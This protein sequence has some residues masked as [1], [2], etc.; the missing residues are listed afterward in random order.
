M[1]KVISTILAAASLSLAAPA[2]MAAEFSDLPQEHWAYNA[3]SE[4]SEAG[5]IS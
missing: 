3:V 5:I 1:K 4:L 2:A